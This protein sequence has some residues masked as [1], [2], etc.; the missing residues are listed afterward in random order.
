MRTARVIPELTSPSFRGPRCRRRGRVWVWRW[1]SRSRFPSAPSITGRSVSSSTT[2]ASARSRRGAVRP[3]FHSPT[4][5]DCHSSCTRPATT[6]S[7]RRGRTVRFRPSV[8]FGACIRCA[9][10]NGT[11]LSPPAFSPA[12]SDSSTS[13]PR[14]S[15]PASRSPAAD[16]A[17]IWSYA[18]SPTPSAVRGEPAEFIT[19]RGGCPIS[20]PSSRFG[21]GSSARAGA[22]PR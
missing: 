20:T 18:R 11:L 15:G 5:T 8:R 7:S 16:R 4:P 14:V 3:R 19:W 10:G 17:G 6:A 2:S 12:F 9:C 22:R 21:S 13:A 1:K